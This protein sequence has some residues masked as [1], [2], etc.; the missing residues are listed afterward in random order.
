MRILLG[1]VRGGYEFEA[2]LQFLPIVLEIVFVDELPLTPFGKA[3]KKA[4]RTPFWE[5]AERAI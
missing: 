5:S 2:A 4:L 3:D 1:A